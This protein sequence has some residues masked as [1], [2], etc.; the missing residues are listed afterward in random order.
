MLRQC[1]LALLTADGQMASKRWL[2][3]RLSHMIP[4]NPHNNPLSPF[5]RDRNWSLQLCDMP[6]VTWVINGS[7]DLSPGLTNHKAH[8]FNHYPIVHHGG[9]D[10]GKKTLPNAFQ[11]PVWQGPCVSIACHESLQPSQEHGTVTSQ[12][13]PQNTGSKNWTERRNT[14]FNCKSWR[15]QYPTF[16]SG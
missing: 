5:D 3:R 16:Q 9:Q 4:L 11:I 15:L 13:N 14:Q 6:K 1:Q 8:V 2:R 12:W 7:L 10:A